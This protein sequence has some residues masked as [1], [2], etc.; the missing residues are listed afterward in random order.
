[1]KLFLKII[2]WVVLGLQSGFLIASAIAGYCA[3]ASSLILRMPAHARADKIL[4]LVTVKKF[5]LLQIIL[6]ITT[7]AIIF[8]LYRF[9]TAW[10]FIR[11]HF[12]NFKASTGQVF[13]Y[14]WCP[15]VAFVVILPFASYIFFAFYL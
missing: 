3:S 11:K 10:E 7:V 13:K 9:N 1:M 5:L 4:Q 15:E 14:A 6:F 12:E 8:L 2:L